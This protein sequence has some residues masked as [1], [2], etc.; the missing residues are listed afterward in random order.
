VSADRVFRTEWPVGPP[1]RRAP[2]SDR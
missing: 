2:L 1:R